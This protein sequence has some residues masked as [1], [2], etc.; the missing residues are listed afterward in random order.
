MADVVTGAILF[1]EFSGKVGQ[2][3]RVNELSGCQQSSV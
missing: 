2:A 1:E 3:Q